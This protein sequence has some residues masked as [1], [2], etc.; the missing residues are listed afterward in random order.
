MLLWKWVEDIFT[1]IIATVAKR[2][3]CFIGW[4]NVNW[5]RACH[6]Y[7]MDFLEIFS[8]GRY[9]WDMKI[10]KILASNS[11]SF[12]QTFKKWEIDDTGW[13]VGGA[14]KY[15]IFLDNLCLNKPLVLKIPL[16]VFLSHSFMYYKLDLVKNWAKVLPLFTHNLQLKL[17]NFSELILSS[18]CSLIVQYM[19][20]LFEKTFAIFDRLSIKSF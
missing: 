6:S 20:F 13:G 7:L 16:G 8:S 4:L 14:A 10:L 1:V 9:H 12:I 15:N 11:N 2:K 19:E 3:R 17:D 18:F 5:S